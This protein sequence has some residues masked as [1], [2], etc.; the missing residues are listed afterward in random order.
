MRQNIIAATF[1]AFTFAAGT[2]VS[3]Q[4]PAAQADVKAC[5]FR[6]TWDAPRKNPL[7]GWIAAQGFAFCDT[8][9]KEHSLVLGLQRKVNDQWQP[10]MDSGRLTDIP[11]PLPGATHELQ[12]NC[13]GVVPGTFRMSVNIVGVSSDGVPFAFSDYSGETSVISC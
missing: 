7:G 10:W 1:L 3:V 2:V 4:A 11:P 13:A 12:A 6:F 5:D 9:P 8:P